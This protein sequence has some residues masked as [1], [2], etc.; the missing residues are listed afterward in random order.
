[1][2]SEL[3]LVIGNTYPVKEQLKALGARWNSDAKGW[4]VPA[5]RVQEAQ[6]LVAGAPVQPRTAGARPT[7]S[8]GYAGYAPTRCKFC[9]AAASRYN[10]IYRNGK[11]RECYV[12]DKEERDMG[13]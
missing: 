7:C 11:C 1:M 10:R 9:G 4:M 8:S 2:T 5:E 12:S 3:V 13:Y 6:A